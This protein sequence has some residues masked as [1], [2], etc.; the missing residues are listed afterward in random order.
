MSGQPRSGRRRGDGKPKTVFPSLLP[1]SLSLPSILSLPSV[2]PSLAAPFP[3]A[4]EGQRGEGT[5]MKEGNGDDWNI[6][7]G[8]IVKEGLMSGSEKERK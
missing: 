6:L 7:S 8:P 5:G 3:L 4:N 2:T 1:S